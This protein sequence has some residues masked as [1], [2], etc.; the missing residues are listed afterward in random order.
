M[1]SQGCASG[2][3]YSEKCVR[4]AC[5]ESQM[6]Q[7]PWRKATVKLP[8]AP[9][10]YS[11]RLGAPTS[12]SAATE[13]A[14]IDCQIKDDAQRIHPIISHLVNQQVNK[15]ELKCVFFY[16]KGNKECRGGGL[17]LY[18]PAEE[19]IFKHSNNVARLARTFKQSNNIFHLR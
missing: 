17:H 16:R 12:P 1:L 7:S 11:E 5:L 14:P 13:A 6:R 2:D 15:S 4:G 18:Y 3:N 9:S 8:F 19:L 10:G